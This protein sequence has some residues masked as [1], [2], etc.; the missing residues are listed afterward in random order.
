MPTKILFEAIALKKCVDAVYNRMA[1]RLAPHIL[2]TKHGEVYLDAV[3]VTREGRPPREVKVG[4]FKV[5]GLTGLALA[6]DTFQTQAVFNPA[7]GKY[8]G[9]TLFAVEP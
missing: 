3:T 1:V 2:Y 7:D 8:E 5:S 4:A 6:D 9:V